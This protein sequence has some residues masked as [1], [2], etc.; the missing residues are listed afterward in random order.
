LFAAGVVR[1]ERYLDDGG[2]ELIANIPESEARELGRSPGV[3][4]TGSR[5]DSFEGP[6][7][8][9]LQRG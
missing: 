9:V 6:H 3:K 1:G 7:P 5:E 4:V 8:C 2:L